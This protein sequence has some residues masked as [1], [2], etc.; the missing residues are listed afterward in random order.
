LKEIKFHTAASATIPTLKIKDIDHHER[1][2]F[3]EWHGDD[4]YMQGLKA[5]G[6]N[7]VLP[8]WQEQWIDRI[9]TMWDADIYK[10]SLHPN[11]WVVHNETL[12]PFNWFFCYQENDMPITLRSL[13]IQIS[14]GRQEKLGNLD[15][16][17]EYAPK[18]LQQVAFNSFRHNY[19]TELIND[20][21]QRSIIH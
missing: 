13:L 10:I 18:E 9:T 2:I 11:S 6:Y 15:L 16:D 7:K 4:F 19:P 14:A 8:D 17:K 1:K 20:A 3:L 5:G 21:I 12:I